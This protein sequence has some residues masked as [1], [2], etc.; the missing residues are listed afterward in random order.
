[1]REEQL[2]KKLETAK[3]NILKKW[4][5]ITD[6]WGSYVVTCFIICTLQLILLK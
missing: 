3:E 5:G 6:E 4:D 2:V 1:M